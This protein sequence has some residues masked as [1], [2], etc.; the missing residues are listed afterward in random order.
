[1]HVNNKGFGTAFPMLTPLPFECCAFI[2]ILP[3]EGFSGPCLHM[4]NSFLCVWLDLGGVDL[5]YSMPGLLV[6]V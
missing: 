3:E 6:K 5:A 1:M 2:L 4:L